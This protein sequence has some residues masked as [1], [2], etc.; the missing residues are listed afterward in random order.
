M[1]VQIYTKNNKCFPSP[2]LKLFQY[3]TSGNVFTNLNKSFERG[4]SK[5]TYLAMLRIIRFDNNE[6]SK[7]KNKRVIITY[8]NRL[9]IMVENTSYSLAYLGKLELT[10]GLS[11]IVAIT[12]FFTKLVTLLYYL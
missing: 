1:F 3:F 8:I 4:I 10:Y 5:V 11:I 6:A 7:L 12:S 2:P 9:T